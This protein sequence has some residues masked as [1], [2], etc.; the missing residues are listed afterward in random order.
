MH[1]NRIVY[2]VDLDAFKNEA[3]NIKK[4][5]KEKYG[6][7]HMQTLNMLAVELGFD[8]YSEYEHYLNNRTLITSI[9]LDKLTITELENLKERIQKSFEKR[10]IL[11][12]NVFFVDNVVNRKI[13][14]MK[15]YEPYSLGLYFYTLPYIMDCRELK[16]IDVETSQLD[17]G[18]AYQILKMVY[19][20]YL[21]NESFLYKSF[22]MINDHQLTSNVFDIYRALFS[23]QEE[24]IDRLTG[25]S[26][27][28]G[29]NEYSLKNTV[30]YREFY[31]ALE[32]MNSNS[33]KKEGLIFEWLMRV[34]EGKETLDSV[35]ENIQLE[36]DKEILFSNKFRFDF[37]ENSKIKTRLLIPPFN[38]YENSDKNFNDTVS[39]IKNNT[40]FEKPFLVG[41]IKKKESKLK[42]LFK[43][44]EYISFSK[45]DMN[46]N[47]MLVGSGGSG[48]TQL[49]YS[50]VAQS[51]MNG[52]GCIFIG[53]GDASTYQYLY[54]LAAKFNVKDKII[55]LSIKHEN[56]I[57]K[58]DI[59]EIVKKNQILVITAPFYEKEVCSAN[60]TISI[61]NKLISGIEKPFDGYYPFSV[62]LNDL[63]K[64]QKNEYEILSKN[65]KRLN[66][67][68]FNF[69]WCIQDLECLGSVRN[70][71]FDNFRNLLLM[72]LENI[73]D[74]DIYEKRI[75]GVS[76][77]E[78]GRL[79]VRDLKSQGPGEFH[80]INLDNPSEYKRARGFYLSLSGLNFENTYVFIS[81]AT[82]FN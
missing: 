26:F 9:N 78:M 81:N 19:N 46:K 36:I 33:K 25:S 77:N 68:N 59:N 11:L 70:E 49:L 21:D 57:N 2:F 32:N 34:E 54:A 43:K 8:S 22:S 4:I 16:C 74:M 14:E 48:K 39:T 71:V 56:E 12:P 61:V 15:E 82:K 79:N 29:T 60:K 67:I 5:S 30:N 7:V 58:I 73:S 40:D 80:Y 27:I 72:K 37:N 75:I 1:Y 63:Y 23:F 64:I 13:K 66:K 6:Y 41:S 20:K 50:Y 47:L 24:Y 55:A 52:K 51:F 3:K 45:M 38:D 69:L 76:N 65:I 17:K 35:I 42:S 44:D 31:F 18:A 53:L 28:R 62:F 10:D